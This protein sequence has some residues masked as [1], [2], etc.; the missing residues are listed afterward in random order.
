MSSSTGL[1]PLRSLLKS[2]E[3]EDPVNLYVHRPLAYLIV[4]LLFRT[5]ITPNGITLMAMLVGVTAGACW[6]EGSHPAM[7]AGGILLWLSAILDGAD[8]IMARAKNMHSQLGRALDGTADMVV[9]TC[10]V[11][12]AY[13]HLWHKHHSLW[14]VAVMVPVVLTTI[15]HLNLYDFYKESYLRMTRIKQG[16]EGED[17]P[18]IE[19]RVEKM[20]QERVRWF[21]NFAMRGVFLPFLKLQERLVRLTNPKGMRGEDMPAATETSA[22]I[23]REHHRMP[24]RLWTFISLAPH[25]YL[26]AIF[27]MFD[28]IDIYLW[29][30]LLGMNFLFIVVLIWQ[31]RASGRT[32]YLFSLMP[33]SAA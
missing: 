33:Q 11:V 6:L 8:G 4:A 32:S 28:R 27:A 10:T 21:V 26:T 18:L 17:R 5:P 22:K 12:P 13:I 2:K 1:P 9:A 16:G 31:R 30:R 29:L 7:I 3:V 24:M 14:Q 25:S 20:R 23:Y 19:A 15:I